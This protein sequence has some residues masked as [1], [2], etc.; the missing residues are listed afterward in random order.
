MLTL[1]ALILLKPSAPC[2]TTNS[3]ASNP[4]IERWQ[5]PHRLT[6]CP[7]VSVVQASIVHQME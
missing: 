6:M 2:L 7:C 5:I 3:G 1:L 4:R